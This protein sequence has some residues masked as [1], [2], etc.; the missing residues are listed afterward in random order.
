MQNN[1]SDVV[2]KNREEILS[3]SID[4]YTQKQYNS[5]GWA[6]DTEAITKNE[7]DDM[8]SKIQVKGS[9]KKFPQSSYGEAI[10]ELND[11][12]HTT[13]GVNNVFAFVT[14]TKNNPQIRRVIRFQVE[15]E[16]EM[17]IIKEKLYERGAFSY[18]YYSFLEQYGITREYSKK[19]ALDY[20]GYQEKVRRGSGRTNSDKAY[21]NSRS[22]Q[23]GSG[24]YAEA[25]SNDIAPIKEV[26]S[27]D[28][29]FFDAEKP[30]DFSLAR[31]TSDSDTRYSIS[32]TLDQDLDLVLNGKFAASK[33][34]VYL[35][36]TSNFM[37]DVIGA[38]SLKVTMPASKAYAAM[39]TRDEYEK[40]PFYPEQDNYHGIGKDDFIEILEKSENPIA[41]FADTPDENGNDRYNRIVLVTD[42]I[43][44][45]VEN[46]GVGNAVVI[47]EVDT[48]GR[49]QGKQVRVN[50][51]IT[52]YPRAQIE[53]DISQAIADGRILDIKTKKDQLSAGRRGANSQATIRKTDL[54]NN[55]AHFWANVKWENEKENLSAPTGKQAPINT[56]K[57][58]SGTVF[59]DLIISQNL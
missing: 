57:A 50:K 31:D 36:E 7:L 3:Y 29:A 55:I 23:N 47:E 39:V 34:E 15:T 43:I 41:A 58:N 16:T 59:S 35:G 20:S 19:S 33:G 27:T 18:T 25:Q 49:F 24:T 26:S 2:T 38:E 11:N 28:D 1:P 4:K 17:E 9:M 37:T 46:G 42:K 21:E 6:R 54:A 12:P 48:K 40:N 5:F 14:G 22:E 45:D 30:K 13:L 56:P 52:V 51:T 8:Y 53:S 44:P 32:P 10:I